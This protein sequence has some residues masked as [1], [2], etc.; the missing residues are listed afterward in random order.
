MPLFCTTSSSAKTSPLRGRAQK[1]KISRDEQK[2][3]DSDD[4]TTYSFHVK[5]I[6]RASGRFVNLPPR[7]LKLERL[8]I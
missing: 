4:M 8:S 3:T 2:L 5:I 7:A 1:Q 6:M